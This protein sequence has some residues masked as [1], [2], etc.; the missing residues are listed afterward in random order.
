[1]RFCILRRNSRWPLK[2]TGKDFCENSPVDSADTLWV[3]NFVKIALTRT[4]IEITVFLHFTHKFKMAAK[5]AG[6]LLLGNCASRLCRYSAGQKFRRNCSI[7]HHF[8]DKCVFVFYAEIQDGHQK[9]QERDFW[10]KSSVDSAYTLWQSLA[11]LVWHWRRG[12]RSNPTTPKDSQPM[13]CD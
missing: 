3:K 5:M 6:K 1:M 10:E 7:S 9:W 2:M 8:Q 11:I 12:P 4:V 13:I